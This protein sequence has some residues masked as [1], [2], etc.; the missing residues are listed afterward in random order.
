MSTTTVTV[1]GTT[2]WTVAIPFSSM[3]TGSYRLTARAVDLA[4]NVSL[5]SQRKFSK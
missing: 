1:N 2:T 5:D 3:Q 4:G